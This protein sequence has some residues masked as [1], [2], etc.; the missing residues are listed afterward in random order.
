M[1]VTSKYDFRPAL[2]YASTT[3]SMIPWEWLAKDSALAYVTEQ[4]RVDM[5]LRAANGDC[6]PVPEWT[7]ICG[8]PLNN[9]MLSVSPTSQQAE[10]L[11]QFWAD[12]S[13][14][15]GSGTHSSSWWDEQRIP[16][17]D[18]AREA[19]HAALEVIVKKREAQVPEIAKNVAGILAGRV[20]RVTEL[21]E[22]GVLRER[23]IAQ[24]PGAALILAL[25]LIVDS[26]K[27]YRRRLRQCALPVC[28]R[29][30]IGVP[31]E[32][33]GQPPNFYCSDKHRDEHRRQRNKERVAASRAGMPV[34]NYRKKLRGR[35]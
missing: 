22:H 16:L 12:H 32:T 10:D 33:R 2:L 20:I 6:L 5:L 15:E 26:E 34:R 17:V 11:R 9:S 3:D 24:S 7:R 8:A 25:S 4:E 18:Q 1:P 35:K 14:R 19:L 21:S 29:F 31:P 28:S 23:V 27:P 13:N 30:A